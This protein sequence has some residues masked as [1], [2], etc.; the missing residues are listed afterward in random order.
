MKIEQL[1]DPP[2]RIDIAVSGNQHCGLKVA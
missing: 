1:F 2:A